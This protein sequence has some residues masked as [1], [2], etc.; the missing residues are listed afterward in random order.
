MLKNSK[1]ELTQFIKQRAVELGFSWCGIAE[2]KFLEREAK[3]VEAFINKGFHGEM[4]Y[5]ENHFEKRL[6]PRKLV[7][8][9]K[10][11]ISFAFNYFQ[12]NN[13]SNSEI[14]VSQYAWGKDYHEV[15]KEKLKLIVNDLETKIG[16]FNARCFVDSAPVLERSW[17][18]N[19]G[20][21]WIGKN[22]MM[23]NKQMG[24][25]F[26]LAE[27]IC[28]L[29]LNYDDAIAKDYC[30]S[31]NKCVESCPTQAIHGDKTMD[32]SKCISYF[33][34]ELKK[35]M[36]TDFQQKWNDWIF[37]C[38]ICQQVCPWNR[39]SKP[40]TE[41]NF[42]PLFDF[43]K[44]TKKDWLEMTDEIFNS[45]FKYSPLK[46]AGLQKIKNNIASLKKS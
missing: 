17:A 36:T 2:A 40:N 30:G 43:E 16:K 27:I 5:L 12:E 11:V 29:E 44:Q 42:M 22:T 41:D 8:G 39:F 21:G 19:A 4:K 35:E 10:S 25:Y 28:D 24:S 23:I 26:F 37:G 34:I 33:T 14:K 9:A 20:F 1:T 15:L 13:F 7:D 45:T 38:D 6:D 46:R 31:C 32:G 18:A 3:H